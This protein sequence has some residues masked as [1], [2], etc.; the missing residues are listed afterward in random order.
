MTLVTVD[1]NILIWGVRGTCTPG[2]EEMLDR[3]AAIVKNIQRNHDLAL[4]AICVAEYLALSTDQ[5]AADELKIL[6]EQFR[7]LP[8]DAKAAKISA[9][10]FRD[11]NEVTELANTRRTEIKADTQIVACA[12]AHGVQLLYSNDKGIR[13]LGKHARMRV[14]DVPEV[15][16]ERG[17]R[18]SELFDGT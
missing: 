8:F 17:L 16:S 3:S 1:T 11:R 9:K 7:I 5:E 6:Q 15:Q 18:Q 13:A 10:L 14:L 12:V 2:Q 4:T